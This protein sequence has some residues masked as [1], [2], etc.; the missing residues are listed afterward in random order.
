[1]VKLANKCSS[2]G[3]QIETINLQKTAE[4]PIEEPSVYPD[5]ETPSPP[6]V[7]PSYEGEPGWVPANAQ[8]GTA[9]P[10]S[11]AEP[12]IEEPPVYPDIEIPS[13]LPVAPSHE[14]ELGRV[15]ANAQVGTAKLQGAFDPPSEEPSSH[16]DIKMPSSLPAA[17]SHEGEPGWI[18]DEEQVGTVNFQSTGET[19]TEEPPVYPDIE[20]LSPPSAGPSYKGELRWIPA[21][22]PISL[23]GYDINCGMVY[24][25]DGEPS[26]SEASAIDTRLKVGLPARGYDA[27]LGYW[28][29]YSMISPAQRG[30]Y[31]EW[32]A[33]NRTDA[34]PASRDLGYIFLFFY[35]VERH[36]LVEKAPELEPIA[37]IVRLVKEYGQTNRSLRSYGSQL[38]HHWAYAQGKEYYI[39][40]LDWLRKEAFPVS[41]RDETAFLLAAY[42]Q[43]RRGLPPAVAF[44]VAW[45]YLQT[46]SSAVVRRANEQMRQ[47]FS[48]R[49]SEAFPTGFVPDSR[50][51]MTIEY[52]PA[53]PSLLGYA[54]G[55]RECIQA[56]I[57]DVLGNRYQF[58]D[59]EKIWD[60]CVTDLAD[61]SR[62][63]G[64]K[65]NAAAFKAYLALPT[66]LREQTPN[67]IE[68]NWNSLLA[69]LQPQ[70]G[71][72]VIAAGE[73]A[74]LVELAKRDKLTATQSRLLADA[75]EVC[76]FAVQPDARHEGSPY[77]WEQ[78]VAVF[79]PKGGTV[80]PPSASCSGAEMLL[81]LCL[82]VAGADGSIANEELSV[83][84]RLIEELVDLPAEDRERLEA[85]QAVLL[86]DPG[87]PRYSLTKLA[88]HVDLV[89]LERVGEI[90]VTIAAGD[91][92]VTKEEVRALEQI[93]K[94]LGL[95]KET[96]DKL[97]AEAQ[98]QADE[99]CA[100]R[101]TPRMPGEAIWRKTGFALDMARVQAIAAETREVINILSEV[102]A[103]VDEEKPAPAANEPEP[104]PIKPVPAKPAEAVAVPEWMASLPTRYQQVLAT[105]VTK[106]SWSRVEFNQLAKKNRL[107]SLDAQDAINE[108]ADETLGGFLLEGEDLVKV[109]RELIH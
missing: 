83:G 81:N 52:R 93:F 40:F 55:T 86:A 99:F 84:R 32:L 106:E 17:P 35:G 23:A 34:D 9:N 30:A 102:M 8:V 5:S 7:A 6:P 46:R 92:L 69:G 79:K 90:L 37:E 45:S 51:P 72:Y 97:L 50:W 38:V 31:L 67:P 14:G 33:A 26:P 48:K 29:R 56:N 91:N 19:P 89:I 22:E 71:C 85:T 4:P 95:R 108:W 101:A 94:A 13:P 47:L 68:F 15:P 44:N 64:Q 11:T 58:E 103:E 74:E 20:I 98:R 96:L 28:S 109:N 107:M 16:P 76:G 82:M 21:N 27:K 2:G 24:V 61:Y 1:L 65:A 10:Q 77:E 73:V 60:S 53:S 62:R 75:I 25:C 104:E 88:K 18:P 54:N 57:P 87:S 78:L 59:I 66:E 80:T 63:K 36:A 12:P 70:N 3:A 100:Q 39:E 41:G 49:Y 43:T 105:L 42:H